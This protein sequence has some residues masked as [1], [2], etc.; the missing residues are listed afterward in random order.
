M[1]LGGGNVGG[2]GSHG[3]RTTVHQ[4]SSSSIINNN[5]NSSSSNNPSTSQ[6][7]VCD[8]MKNFNYLAEE[9]IGIPSRPTYTLVYLVDL[10]IPRYSTR[11]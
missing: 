7:Q 3:R 10:P 9:G 1:A 11:Y 4:S 5:N 8:G 2:Q 6:A